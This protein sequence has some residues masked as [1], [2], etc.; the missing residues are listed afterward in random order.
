MASTVVRGI[1]VGP[2]QGRTSNV[3]YE[4]PE[5]ASE[6][7]IKGAVLI[8]AAGYLSQGAADL[9]SG[10]IGIAAEPAHNDA[11]AGLHNIRYW[12]A[13][14]G[15]VFEATLED[16]TNNNHVLVAADRFAKRALQYDSTNKRWY[17]DENDAGATAAIIVGFKDAVGA[18]KGRVYFVF[19]LSALLID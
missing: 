3:T 10:I 19:E 13:L 8:N 5:A 2:P 12:P 6:T 1:L 9:T 16:E 11:S 14:P 18:T 4:G 7:F 17:I 15:A